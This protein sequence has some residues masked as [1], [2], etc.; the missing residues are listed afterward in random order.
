MLSKMFLLKSK[1]SSF[2]SIQNCS[3]ELELL[4]LAEPWITYFRPPFSSLWIKTIF[5]LLLQT[6]NWNLLPTSKFYLYKNNYKTKNDSYFYDI[7]HLNKNG[8]TV[9]T[10]EI[11]AF[12]NK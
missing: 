2:S 11:S 1:S 10:Q 5:D 9:F 4:R 6:D 8:A 3:V 7:S 12:I